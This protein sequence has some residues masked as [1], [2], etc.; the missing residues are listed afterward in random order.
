MQVINSVEV[1]SLLVQALD[2]GS[3]SNGNIFWKGYCEA[4]V[5]LLNVHGGNIH[6]EYKSDGAGMRIPTKLVDGSGVVMWRR[7]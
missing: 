2:V 4:L 7:V 5:D 6:L 1:E 3:I